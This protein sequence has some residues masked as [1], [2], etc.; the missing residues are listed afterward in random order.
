L[1]TE[2]YLRDYLFRQGK[3][4]RRIYSPEDIASEMSR[5]YLR[6]K[7]FSPESL[8]ALQLPA[9][10]SLARLGVVEKS[11]QNSYMLASELVRLR[12]SKCFYVSYISTAEPRKCLRCA[13]AELYDFPKMK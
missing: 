13:H 6:Y 11:D 10:D 1:E 4:G 8:F 7:G 9:F 5:T 3:L 12:C 2:W